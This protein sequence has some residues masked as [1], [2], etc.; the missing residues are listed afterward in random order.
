MKLKALSQ[1]GIINK[2]MPQ[3]YITFPY[4]CTPLN[5][6][7]IENVFQLSTHVRVETLSS[8]LLVYGKDH[9]L[10]SR[11]AKSKASEAANLL[12]FDLVLKDLLSPL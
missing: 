3:T 12:A 4:A 6:P 1:T 5:I 11:S 2:S 7:Y 8:Q 10:I 9:K